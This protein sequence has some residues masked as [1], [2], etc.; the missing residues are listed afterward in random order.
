MMNIHEQPDSLFE[1]INLQAI[2]RVFIQIERADTTLEEGR[3][4]LLRQLLLKNFHRFFIAANLHDVASMLHKSSLQVRMRIEHLHK[5]IVQ[6]PG[7]SI[8]KD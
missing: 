6:P 1:S 2:Q 3:V 8:L 4:R 5:S 7:I